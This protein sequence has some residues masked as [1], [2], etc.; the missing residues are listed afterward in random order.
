MV[1]FKDIK[2]YLV[3]IYDK[4]FTHEDIKSL[5]A[6]YESPAGKKYLDTM[7][8][9]TQEM[10]SYSMQKGMEVFK[11][12]MKGSKWEAKQTEARTKGNLGALRSAV[13]IF[14]G[15]HEGVWPKNVEELIPNYLTE[16]PVEL[17]SGSSKV[18]TTLTGE[19]GWYYHLD[20]K[21]DKDNE[22]GQVYVNLKGNDTRGTAY[23]DY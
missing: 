21:N 4:Y 16:I 9:I 11:E 6:F 10:M 15:D 19:G 8:E 14:Y 17:I 2:E 18:Y 1:K 7:P 23:K 3:T 12:E 22:N 13:A 20:A 5:I